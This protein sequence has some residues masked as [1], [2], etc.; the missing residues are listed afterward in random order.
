[1]TG[2]VIL[3][4]DSI[5]SHLTNKEKEAEL[6]MARQKLR[7]QIKGMLFN[8]GWK[9]DLRPRHGKNYIDAVYIAPNGCTHWSIVKAYYAFQKQVSSEGDDKGDKG[10]HLSGK[11][12]KKSRKSSFPP[13][14]PIPEEAL[15]ILKHPISRRRTRKEM[16][17]AEMKLGDGSIHKKKHKK[18]L[19]DKSSKRKSSCAKGVINTAGKKTHLG[20]HRRKPKGCALLVRS[21]NHDAETGTDVYVPYAWKRTT[22]SWMIDLGV[23]PENAEVKYMN[24]RHTKTLLKGQITRDGI[25]C[26]CCSKTL[27]VSGFEIH[28]GSK[29]CN[30]YQNI[31]VEGDDT[32]LLECQINAWKKQDESERKGFYFIDIHGDDPNDDTCGICGDGGDLICCDGCPSTFHQSCLG[33]EVCQNHFS[34]YRQIAL[35]IGSFL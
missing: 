18:H 19:K 33:T 35:L 8:A 16:E 31:V 20:K 1:V 23:M 2:D 10:R 6:R 27:T 28:S 21:F 24:R 12:C 9:L 5:S 3:E 15:S 4:G 34:F 17:E 13:F 30:P 32:S 7:G 25:H 11:P 26:S 14:A 29:Q 22:L